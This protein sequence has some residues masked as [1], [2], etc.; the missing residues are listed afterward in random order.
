MISPSSTVDNAV[1]SLLEVDFFISLISASKDRGEHPSTSEGRDDRRDCE[2]GGVSFL[3]KGEWRRGLDRRDSGTA[4]DSLWG[5]LK[6]RCKE[7]D[8]TGQIKC[9]RAAGVAQSDGEEEQGEARKKRKVE[10]IGE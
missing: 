6:R 10:G 1:S 3:L 8:L 7:L 9:D 2:G 5:V 4:W